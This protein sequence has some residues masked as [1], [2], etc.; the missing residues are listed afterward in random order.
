[1]V[2]ESV[3]KPF[4]KDHCIRCHGPQLQKAKLRLD[5]FP[6]SHQAKAD[7]IE[8]WKLVLEKLE[9]GEM[10]PPKSPRPKPAQVRQI[11]QWL[12]AELTK[13][14]AIA[15]APGESAFPDK[16]NLID[17]AALFDPKTVGTA[18]TS[19]RIWRLSPYG[20][21]ELVDRL[22]GGRVTDK[23]KRAQVVLPFGLTSDPGFRDYAFRYK[24]S[25][26]E[27]EQMV[28]NAKMVVSFLLQR[29]GRW[30]PPRELTD[31]AKS[32]SPPNAA[33]V[34]KAVK[35]MYQHVLCRD[36]KPS[37]LERYTAFATK[38]IQRFGNRKGIVHGL[39]PVL[40]HPE[41]VFRLELGQGKPDQHG[42]VLLAPKELAMSI[43][44][45]LT[46]RRPDKPLLDAAAHGKLHSQKDV[47]REVHRLLNDDEIPKPRILR[48]FHEYFGYNKAPDV[49]KDE[50]TLKQAGIRGKY[51]PENLVADTDRLV[52]HILQK[53]Q[54][55]LQELLTTDKTF[56]NSAG[57]AH[58]LKFKKRREMQA[59]EKGIDPP[60]HPFNK[61][62]ELFKH[63][64]FDPSRWKVEM[65]FTLPKE[66]RAG[67]LTQPAWLIAH[68]T[69]T[70]N[71]AI[72]RGKWVREHLIGGHIP[73]T[74]VTVE[75][76]LPD[77][78]EMPLRH[79][80][81]VTRDAYCWKC[82]QFMDPL[83]LPFEMYDHY[84]QYRTTE[85]GK[86]VDTSGAILA[87]GD[88][89]LNGSVKNAIELIHKLARSERAQQ[90][91]VR[92]AFRYWMGRNETLSDAP[93]LQSAYRAYQKSNGSMKAL[94]SAL[95]TSDSFI[96]RTAGA[97]K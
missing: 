68:S 17:H 56:V 75:A 63:Y 93:T 25:G 9:L 76:K 95:L 69:N 78:P 12:R 27:T 62:N 60:M 33:Q 5:N 3:V 37:E 83:G 42:R 73:D 81:R 94:I 82:H 21:R 97:R 64:N 28:L 6:K 47:Q 44:Y 18:A 11:I 79:R 8:S 87:S 53:D 65:P 55:V 10:P 57:V 36:P 61:K 2:F 66:Q 46:D 4:L 16:G 20:Y 85:L 35:Y 39:A 32:E 58:W 29:R 84:G 19:A 34:Q 45:A 14:N 41:A 7:A 23:K 30:H 88:P 22:T 15:N 91:F 26:S 31:I 67:I 1:M 89:K 80:M 77:E 59:R 51:R 54:D 92:H 40:L 24:I 52:E 96:Y 86:P 72:H 43:S 48:F 74:P 13:V 70:D 49:F 38:G 50:Y 90:V 71:H